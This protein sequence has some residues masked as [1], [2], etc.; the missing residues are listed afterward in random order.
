MRKSTEPSVKPIE[1]LMRA[2]LKMG[3]IE[4]RNAIVSH[5]DYL[6]KRLASCFAR[7]F[8]FYDDL[9]SEGVVVLIDAVEKCDPKRIKLFP[10]YANSRISGRMKQYI[11]D[12]EYSVFSV[13]SHV[14]EK[15]F[16]LY[17][18]EERMTAELG[19]QPTAKIMVSAGMSEEKINMVQRARRA[20]QPLSLNHHENGDDTEIQIAQADWDPGELKTGCLEHD[21]WR[22]L[23]CLGELERRLIVLK[24]FRGFSNTAL[25]M[26]LGM[27]P[28]HVRELT[29]RAKGELKYYLELMGYGKEDETE[30]GSADFI[31]RFYRGLDSTEAQLGI[32]ELKVCILT[33]LIE[34]ARPRRRSDRKLMAEYLGCSTNTVQGALSRLQNKRVILPDG[35]YGSYRLTREKFV[36]SYRKNKALKIFGVN[37]TRGNTYDL[38]ELL[39]SFKVGI[40]RTLSAPCGYTPKN[41]RDGVVSLGENEI[42]VAVAIVAEILDKGWSKYSYR[43]VVKLCKV[44]IQLYRSALYCLTKKGVLTRVQTDG[45]GYELRRDI[46][47]IHLMNRVSITLFKGMPIHMGY[48]YSLKDLAIVLRLIQRWGS[49]QVVSWASSAKDK[50]YGARYRKTIM[51]PKKVV[52]LG[53]SEVIATAV[54]ISLSP[55]G[56]IPRGIGRSIIGLTKLSKSVVSSAIG[57]LIQKGVWVKTKKD[58]QTFYVVDQQQVLFVNKKGQAVFRGKGE[59]DGYRVVLKHNHFY[60]LSRL[61]RRLQRIYH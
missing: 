17:R 13:P 28:N 47:M 51:E 44:G 48:C 14:V 39:S 16:K 59:L 2:Y 31:H 52:K 24:Y 23:N 43:R 19:C 57:H 25:Q 7:R 60:H 8:G 61:A 49:E 3:D 33:L 6:V 9:Y 27:A 4:R 42:R 36:I 53:K 29:M 30:D 38:R 1:D 58:G 41:M 10:R 32:N 20:R 21:V 34:K 40:A 50:S 55:D 11:R 15:D 18:L 46:V 26:A 35:P 22:A 37:L 54:A 12:Q 56:Y 45:G 5:Y